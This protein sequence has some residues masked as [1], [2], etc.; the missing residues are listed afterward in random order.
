LFESTNY[1]KIL[2]NAISILNEQEIIIDEKTTIRPDKIIIKTDEVAIIDF[3]TGLPKEKDKK[4]IHT[5]MKALQNMGYTQVRGHLYYTAK[6]E[7]IELL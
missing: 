6:Q 4:Q 1:S 3:K 2:E 7:F 5:Y